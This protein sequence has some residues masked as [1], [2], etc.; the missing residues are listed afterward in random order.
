MVVAAP[1]PHTCSHG[2]IKR[3]RNL[4]P[5]A[6]RLRHTQLLR[7]DPTRKQVVRTTRPHQRQAPSP[8]R[9][10]R[11]PGR[12]WC[13][14][15]CRRLLAVHS[16]VQL[17]LAARSHQHEER[18]GAGCA[19]GGVGGGG[20][21]WRW[22]GYLQLLLWRLVAVRRDHT[23]TQVQQHWRYSTCS[24]RTPQCFTTCS[25]SGALSY[26]GDTTNMRSMLCSRSRGRP[27]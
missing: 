3:G 13:R 5:I 25:C 20:Q 11:P 15:R 19:C 7:P 22:A 26:F 4:N 1:A 2:Q 24:I 27:L 18:L 12:P 9:P 6:R 21:C 14:W 8:A 23:T 16:V 10:Q 17:H